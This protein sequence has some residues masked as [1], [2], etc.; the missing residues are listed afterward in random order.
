MAMRF[1]SHAIA[2][3]FLASSVALG[4]EPDTPPVPRHWQSGVFTNLELRAAQAALP[5]LRRERPNWTSYSIEVLELEDNSLSVHFY[6]PED[7]TNCPP[8]PQPPEDAHVI[9]NS[10]GLAVAIAPGPF[11]ENGLWVTIRN[12]DLRVT[13]IDVEHE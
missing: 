6:R 5:T 9:T 8:A 3:S 4:G 13:N 2:L 7:C 10:E 11:Y 12:S 1:V